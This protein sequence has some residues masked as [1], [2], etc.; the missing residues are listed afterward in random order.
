MQVPDNLYSVIF[1]GTYLVIIWVFL[2]KLIIQNIKGGKLKARDAAWK[3]NFLAYFL[4]GFGDLFHLG[5]RIYIFIAGYGPDDHFTNLFIGLGYIISGLTM[6]YFYIAVFHGWA[7]TYGTTYSTPKKIKLY[8]V[9]IYIA[10]ILR[11]I[12]MMLPYNR[13][14]EGDATVDFGFDFRIITAIPLYIIGILAVFLLFSHS[15]AEAKDLK[16]ID[17]IRNKGNF[18]AS[19]WFLVSYITYTITLLL[20]AIYPLTG[21]FMIPKTIAYLIAF[22]YH[23]KTM[24]NRPID[25]DTN[26]KE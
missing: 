19:I 11:F 14:Y 22:F 7:K 6:T 20:V 8:T 4:L 12:L 16:G 23:Y 25:I 2:I 9:I 24:L 17:P 18:Y 10:F 13:W 5:F 1:M 3:W 15:R 21:L 26:K